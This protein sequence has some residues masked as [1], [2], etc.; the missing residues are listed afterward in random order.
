MNTSER[1]T[2]G[3]K[4]VDVSAPPGASAARA[5][6]EDALIWASRNGSTLARCDCICGGIVMADPNAP[7]Y[8][9]QAHNFTSRHR[10]WRAAREG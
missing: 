5:T 10:A 9:V 1:P 2:A 8:G 7:A 6:S 3:V 4:R